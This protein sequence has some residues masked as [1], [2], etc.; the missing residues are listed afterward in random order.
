M[1]VG[2][3]IKSRKLPKYAVSDQPNLIRRMTQ[4]LRT[5]TFTITFY[6]YNNTHVNS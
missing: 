2:I 5:V 1:K 4:M 6:A 3:N